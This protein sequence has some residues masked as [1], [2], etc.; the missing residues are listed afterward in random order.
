MGGKSDNTEGSPRP[1]HGRAAL[2]AAVARGARLSPSYL[3]LVALATAIAHVG[4]L[5]DSAPVVIGA[6]L[7]SPLLGPIMAF[8]F[9]VAIFE[10]ALLRRAALA[11]GAGMVLAVL[12]SIVLTWLSPIQ[13]VTPSILAR[14]RPNLLD[15]LVAV[16]G[17]IAG[18]YATVRREA[19]SLVGVAI[20]TALVPPL[21]VVGFSIATGRMDFAWG[22]LL[23]FITNATAIAL[24]ATITARVRGFGTHLSPRQSW[25]QTAGIL[26]TLVALAIP[27]GLRLAANVREA[28]AQSAINRQLQELAGPGARIDRLDSNLA[29]TPAQVDAVVMAP[30]FSDGLQDRFAD[31]VEGVLGRNANVRLVQIRSGTPEADDARRALEGVIA[32]ERTRKEEVTRLRATLARIVDGDGSAVLVDPERRSARVFSAEAL[33]PPTLAA[34]Q[35]AFPGWTLTWGEAEVQP[36]PAPSAAVTSSTD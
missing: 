36:D 29:A 15:L 24:M 19:I 23:L 26:A 12:I 31:R 30:S 2:L 16:F 11:L 4:L 34:L 7:I 5:M 6:M 18:A 9:G 10:L 25:A 13:D 8:G 14:V 3:M 20:A 33:P 21:A 32:T 1:N 28:R 17:G 22:A 27:L 35:I